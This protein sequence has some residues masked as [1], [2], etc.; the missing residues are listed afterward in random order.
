MQ[1]IIFVAINVIFF[2][3]LY[4]SVVLVNSVISADIITSFGEYFSSIPI[5][6]IGDHSINSVQNTIDDLNKTRSDNTRVLYSRT[7]DFEAQ[8]ADFRCVEEGLVVCHPLHK[9]G[10]PDLWDRLF[11]EA[12]PIKHRVIILAR[13]PLEVVKSQ[14]AYIAQ[15]YMS[16]TRDIFYITSSCYLL[17]RGFTKWMDSIDHP[18]RVSSPD[19]ATRIVSPHASVGSQS[20]GELVMVDDDA[21]SSCI[22]TG[23]NARC[24]E[25][26]S[27]DHVSGRSDIDTGVAVD[28]DDS[29]SASSVPEEGGVVD[30]SDGVVIPTNRKLDW[31]DCIDGFTDEHYRMSKRTFAFVYTGK[32]LTSSDLLNTIAVRF[33]IDTRYLVSHVSRGASNIYGCYIC[34]RVAPRRVNTSNLVIPGVHMRHIRGA[35]GV[36]WLTSLASD[37]SWTNAECLTQNKKLIML[38]ELASN[39]EVAFVFAKNRDHATHTLST[40]AKRIL[41]HGDSIVSDSS[42]TRQRTDISRVSQDLSVVDCNQSEGAPLV[43]DCA[44]CEAVNRVSFRFLTKL[45][46][47]AL[48]GLYNIRNNIHGVYQ[49]L[50]TDFILEH[51]MT[52]C[53][54]VLDRINILCDVFSLQSVDIRLI[55]KQSID[56][57]IGTY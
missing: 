38:N 32:R 36:S 57:L 30:R 25:G 48:M 56:A 19:N 28:H 22:Y 45:D 15:N 43:P 29:R 20:D 9:F 50:V 35:V 16:R 23:D 5:L 39:Q 27:T 47:D 11:S 42:R 10:R 2:L 46:V 31:C 17:A 33:G 6:H 7:G 55:P 54:T 4:S 40:R 21:C 51:C 13:M 53:Q 1:N 37:V 8:F 18:P 24:C 26:S 41:S 12:D 44:V 34:C 14:T 49:Q 52:R 3:F